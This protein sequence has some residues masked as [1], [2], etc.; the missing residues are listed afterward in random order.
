MKKDQY[1][2]GLVSVSFRQHTPKEILEAVKAAGLSCI[3][4]G[5]DVHAPHTDLG[6]L[7]EIAEMLGYSSVY[8]FS[9]AFKENFGMSP[10]AYAA[11]HH[12]EH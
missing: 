12:S 10:K 1:K 4:W 6:R 3:E 5:S 7:G 2:L 9:K 8:S 11:L